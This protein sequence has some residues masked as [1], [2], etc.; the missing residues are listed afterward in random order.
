MS[1]TNDQSR[2]K[3]SGT[4]RGALTLEPP[5]AA[6]EP[7]HEPEMV[8]D[9]GSQAL[10]EALRSSF[11]IVKF[12]MV[13]LMIVFFCSGVFTVPSQKRAIILR[14]GKPVGIGE[15][16]LLEPGLHWSWPYPI[17]EKIFIPLGQQTVKSTVG[18]YVDE[19]SG[20][21]GSLNPA[22]EGYSITADANII[23]VRLTANYRITDPIMYALHFA[24][25]SNVVQNI[26]NNAV[27]YA[28]ARTKV[29][30]ALRLERARFQDAILDRAKTLVM[31]QG[32]GITLDNS[33]IEIVPP[34]FLK[35]K[36][37]GVNSADAQRGE[38]V[39]KA[40]IEASRTTST[41]R[42]DATNIVNV[43][44][45][46][47]TRM[48]ETTHA[49][50]QYFNDQLPFYK[51]NQDLFMARLQIKALQQ[52]MTNAQDKIFLGRGT[53]LRLMLNREPQ[54]PPQAAPQ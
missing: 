42:S 20:L 14:F 29:D 44:L 17:D 52:V 18:W 47:A 23:H 37:E 27:V 28:S 4:G 22:A 13:G 31:S 34:R 39:Q 3:E 54:K 1:D 48:R 9:S 25:A 7:P 11:V 21:S 36:F 50:A 16:M 19:D 8:E 10:A 26:L 53:Q 5:K 40:K 2:L 32:L 33:S 49:D 38:I 12:L 35:D 24:N 6:P 41:A 46:E 43:A 30:D 45:S 51:E 15:K